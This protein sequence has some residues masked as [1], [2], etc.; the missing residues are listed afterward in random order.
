MAQSLTDY[1]LWY[2][3][4]TP[5]KKRKLL[6]GGKVCEYP[7]TQTSLYVFDGRSYTSCEGHPGKI[8]LYFLV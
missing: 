5:T 6:F 7:K 2:P 1:S 3:L 8:L 4:T